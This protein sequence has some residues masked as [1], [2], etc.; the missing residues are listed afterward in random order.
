MNLDLTRLAKLI[1]LLWL[2]SILDP[3]VRS[4]LTNLVEEQVKMP[5]LYLHLP[6]ELLSKSKMTFQ[7]TA[8]A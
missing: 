1:E 4:F 8:K 6:S 2:K 7:V 3:P 5:T